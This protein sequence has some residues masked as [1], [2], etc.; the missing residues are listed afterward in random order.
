MILP[1][2]NF[3]LL[4]EARIHVRFGPRTPG[5]VRGYGKI[6]LL[7][8]ALTQFRQQKNAHLLIVP[9]ISPEFNTIG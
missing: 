7:A 4:P 9:T 2:V 3:G 5:G 6:S 1:D 8:E